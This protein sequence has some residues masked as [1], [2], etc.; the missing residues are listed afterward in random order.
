MPNCRISGILHIE[1]YKFN[2]NI[3]QISAQFFFVF[4]ELRFF[5]LAGREMMGVSIDDDDGE[6]G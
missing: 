5:S 2:F 1:T 4:F 6:D 3:S